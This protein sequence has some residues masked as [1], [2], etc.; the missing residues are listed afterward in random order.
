VVA[1]LAGGCE[2]EA[3]REGVDVV[4]ADVAGFLP[5][6]TEETIDARL[7]LAFWPTRVA[8]GSDRVDGRAL[9]CLKA[10]VEDGK[11]W[12][13]LAAD[14]VRSGSTS[15]IVLGVGNINHRS[16]RQVRSTERTP[17][18]AVKTSTDDIGSVYT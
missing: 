4:V 12:N 7:V 10:S 9:G 6:A 13:G 15:V 8:P 1:A 2:E 3:R 17:L 18:P 11:K 16:H 5:W 14:E